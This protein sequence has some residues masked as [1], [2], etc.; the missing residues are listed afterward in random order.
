MKEGFKISKVTP[1]DTLKEGDLLP[2]SDFAQLS[3]GGNFV[4]MEYFESK[5]HVDT[6]E[7]TPGVFTI[8]KGGGGFKLEPTSFVKDQIL[9]TFVNTEQITKSINMFFTRLDVYKKHGIEI[10][11]FSLFLYGAPGTGKSTSISTVAEK[12]GVDGKTAFI[13]WPTDKYEAYLIKDFIKTFTYNGVDRLIFIVEDIG[14]TEQDQVKQRSDSSLLSLLDNQEKTFKI[15]VCIIATTNFPEMFL[16]NL[17]NRPGRFDVKVEVGY[18]APAERVQLLQFFAKD[19]ITDESIKMMQGSETNEFSVAHIKH[20]VLFAD[21]Y[22][23]PIHEMCKRTIAEIKLFKKEFSKK[24][25][26]MGFGSD[27]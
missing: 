18:P 20:V 16:G 4:Q 27:D 23:I 12:Y 1:L 11:K 5:D 6:Y 7:V 10:P 21:L 26:T 22:N 25:S 19:A 14:G 2:V 9:S 13:I 15:P 8:K 3:P 24:N 17:T